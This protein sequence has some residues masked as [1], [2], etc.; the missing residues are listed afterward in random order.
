M[1]A[2]FKIG[3]TVRLR[4]GGPLMTVKSVSTN[5]DGVPHVRCIW[6]D[7]NKEGTGYYPAA[8]V[9]ADDGAPGMA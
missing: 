3:D 9:E 6:F 4:S 7:N 1:T 5:D 2:T 8:T